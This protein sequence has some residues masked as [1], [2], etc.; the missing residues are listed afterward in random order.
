MDTIT[1]ASYVCVCD[2]QTVCLY[3]CYRG[4]IAMFVIDLLGRIHSKINNNLIARRSSNVNLCHLHT[5][6]RTAMRDQRTW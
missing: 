6:L 4:S 2:E 1:I 3:Q 5:K